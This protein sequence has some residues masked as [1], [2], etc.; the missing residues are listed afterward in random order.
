MKANRAY[1]RVILFYFTNEFFIDQYGE[2]AVKINGNFNKLTLLQTVHLLP[3]ISNTLS[4]YLRIQIQ[5]R[6][7]LWHPKKKKNLGVS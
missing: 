6:R 7:K 1:N 5:L 2:T 3:L 4:C